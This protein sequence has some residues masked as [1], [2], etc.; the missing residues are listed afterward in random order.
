MGIFAITLEPEQDEDGYVL[1]ET[2][3]D[4]KRRT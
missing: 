3:E 2:K 1:E 4:K